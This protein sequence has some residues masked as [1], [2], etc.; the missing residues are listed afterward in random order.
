MKKTRQCLRYQLVTTVTKG[1]WLGKKVCLSCKGRVKISHLISRL[2]RE[3]KST[4]F[5]EKP[6]F[7]TEMHIVNLPCSLPQRDLCSLIWE[8]KG[9]ESTQ[10]WGEGF[11][12]T[13]APSQVRF[14]GTVEEHV[15]SQSIE[16][17][18]RLNFAP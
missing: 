11:C 13:L 3:R 1:F 7:N 18:N 14:L 9:K 8:R 17:F 12:R 10:T 4:I 5:E 2:S 6:C 16:M 15:V